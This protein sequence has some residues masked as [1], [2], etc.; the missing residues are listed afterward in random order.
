VF[1]DGQAMV[2]LKTKGDIKAYPLNDS[3]IKVKYL[4]ENLLAKQALVDSK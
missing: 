4:S 1:V 3:K 2:H